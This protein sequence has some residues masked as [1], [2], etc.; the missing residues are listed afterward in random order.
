MKHDNNT[1]KGIEE[2]PA[3]VQEQGERREETAEHGSEVEQLR[4]IA[5]NYKEMLQRLQAE[6]ENAAKRT[7]KEK[8]EYR[9]LVNAKLLEE[10]LPLV[11]SMAEAIKHAAKS[12]NNEMKGGVEKIL[13][14]LMKILERNGVK[15]MQATGKKFDAALHECLLTASEQDREDWVVLEELQKGYTINGKVL[16]PA[17]V[18]VNKKEERKALR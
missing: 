18:K 3:N 8:E 9:K 11:D 2:G 6:F 15:Q 7:A 16:R 13:A 14:Q 12:G 10:F 5:E 4:K 1:P 17:K